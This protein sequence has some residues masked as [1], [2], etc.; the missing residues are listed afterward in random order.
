MCDFVS[1]NEPAHP[2]MDQEATARDQNLRSLNVSGVHMPGAIDL[3]RSPGFATIGFVCVPAGCAR[4]FVPGQVV[5]I[6]GMMRIAGELREARGE[7]RFIDARRC[8]EGRC[9][10]LVCVPTRFRSPST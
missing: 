1:P 9:F 6:G 5:V 10:D 7:F 4:T 8:H 3:D 2:R